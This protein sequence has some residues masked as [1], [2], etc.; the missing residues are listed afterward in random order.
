P[1]VTTVFIHSCNVKEKENNGNLSPCEAYESL[2]LE[3]LNTYEEIRKKYASNENNTFRKRLNMSQVYWVQY[4]DRFIKALFPLDKEEYTD[5]QTYVDC[6][7]KELSILTK[8]R[9]I[10]L[11]VWLDGD[12]NRI[13][14]PTSILQ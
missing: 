11:S 13:D 12:M 10:E 3:M 5:K 1:F 2:D 6:K 8:N 7:C 9:I 4:R 14:C